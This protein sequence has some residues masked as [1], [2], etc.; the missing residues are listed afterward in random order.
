MR[1]MQNMRSIPLPRFYSQSRIDMIHCAIVFVSTCIAT[2][3][4]K[5]QRKMDKT[6]ESNDAETKILFHNIQ[7]EWWSEGDRDIYI[8]KRPTEVDWIS[9]NSFISFFL[10]LFGLCMCVCVCEH[11][12]VLN[13]FPIESAICNTFSKYFFFISWINT[14][15]F[16]FVWNFST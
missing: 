2:W 3:S 10:C 15:K 7:M 11:V 6:I 1:K 5:F 8:K 9:G 12:C 13:V 14:L 4:E 16:F